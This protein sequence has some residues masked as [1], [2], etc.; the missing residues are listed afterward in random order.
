MVPAGSLCLSSICLSLC[1]SHTLSIS[2]PSVCHIVYL[3]VPRFLWNTAVVLTR[4][5]SCYHFSALLS[6]FPYIKQMVIFIHQFLCRLRS[7][8]AHGDHFVWHLSVR[9]SICLS[10]SHTFSVVM[11][12]YV[13]QA[14][15]TFLGMLP[16]SSVMMV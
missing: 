1:L 13:S 9:L 16:L 8:A 15:H 3:R 10:G 6:L 5:R 11:H 12:S 4:I 2:H 7:I 14:T